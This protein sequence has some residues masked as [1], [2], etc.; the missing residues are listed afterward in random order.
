MHD[1][2]YYMIWIVRNIFCRRATGAP[3]YVKNS[4]LH[5]DLELPTISKYMKDAS[6][7]FFDIA[8]NHPN[9]LL[10]SAV[11]YEPPP[12]H[13]FCRRSRNILIDPSDDHTVE[14]EKLIELNKMAID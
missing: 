12:P 9:P 13:Y 4:V 10:V 3:W 7:H 1:L 11:S 14:V 5:R 6:E 2:I 8:K